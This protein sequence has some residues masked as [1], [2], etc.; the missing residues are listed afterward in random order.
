M[1][2][3]GSLLTAADIRMGD[4]FFDGFGSGTGILTITDSGAVIADNLVFG[5]DDA[6]LGDYGTG[7]L[8]IGSAVGDAAAAAGTLTVTSGELT[9]GNGTG[10]VNFNHTE[11]DYEFDLDITG[12]FDVNVYSGTTV[13]SGDSVYTGGTRVYGGVLEVNGGTLS[14]ADVEISNG[15]GSDGAAVITGAGST[16][17]TADYFT[18][19]SDSGTGTLTI[20]DGGALTSGFVTVG[21]S[22]GEGFAL[23]TGAG[24]VLT[25]LG[26]FI[27]G[28]DSTGALTVSE[29]GEV[30]SDTLVFGDDGG[31]GELNV[32]A[33]VG[34]AAAGVGVLTI[35]SGELETGTGTGIVNFNHTGVG[36]AFGLGINGA[37][38]V[39]HYAGETALGAASDYTGET[40]VYGGL[41]S[42]E[43]GVTA[44]DGGVTVG[45]GVGS[46]G[47]VL[48]TG[49]GSVWTTGD[50]LVGADGGEGLLTIAAGGVAEAGGDAVVGTDAS[51]LG[52]VVVTGT[53][54]LWDI[55]DTL[56][57]GIE[58]GD[59]T[60][61]VEDGG[62]VTSAKGYVGVGL[63]S[64]GHALI[65]GTGSSWT[66]TGDLMV[67]TE[68]DDADIT[69]E[70]GAVVNTGGDAVVGEGAGSVGTATV[71]GTGSAWNVTGDLAVGIDGGDGTLTVSDDGTVESATG[72]V[73]AGGTGMALI[74][75]TGSIWTVTGDLDIGDDGT[76][77]VADAGEV[78]ADGINIDA[79][80]LLGGDGFV[81]GNV[82]NGG[83]VRPGILGGGF[84]TLTITG[85]YTGADGL[86]YLRTALGD[87]SSP[88]DI[89]VID[90]G[91]ATGSTGIFIVNTLPDCCSGAATAG[92]G[93]LIVDAQNGAIIDSDA[94]TLAE[95]VEAGIY[96]YNL[97]QGMG[98]DLF[99]QSSG[100]RPI[101]AAY[102]AAP[103]LA[104][105]FAEDALGNV[106]DRL[107]PPEEKAETRYSLNG[108]LR[109]TEF[110]EGVWMRAFGSRRKVD[111]GSA[112]GAAYKGS[113]AGVQV[114]KDIWR[115]EN[116]NGSRDHAG[117]Y[118]AQGHADADATSNLGNAGDISLDATAAG[119]YW[120]RHGK[121][122]VYAALSG[123]YARIH[124]LKVKSGT[125]SISPGGDSFG[126][127]AEIGKTFRLRGAVMLEPSAQVMYQ[128]TRF[129][130]DNDGAATVRIDDLDALTARLGL[131]ASRAVRLAGGNTLEPW[132]RLDLLHKETDDTTVTV[133]GDRFTT[134][135]GGTQ[136]EIKLGITLTAAERRRR[137][138]FGVITHKPT[139]PPWALFAAT[140]YLHD[141]AGP[142]TQAVSVQI[143]AKVCW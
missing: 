45:T 97:F 138:T 102:G 62:T 137:T 136:A 7:I 87:D 78:A 67:G 135:G 36:Y 127:S 4:S 33:A 44:A 94:F 1:T 64:N 122:G 25:S 65:T 74:T 91:H 6:G 71:T 142:G 109:S 79:G 99:L 27:V 20:E 42:L 21:S 41:L 51:S 47:A 17:T 15:V 37:F 100:L 31:A 8:N 56:Y 80:G 81:T 132:T 101:I 40:T 14:D 63:G 98:G 10:V 105:Q 22:S 12:A 2:G 106:H 19:G 107:D 121:S 112:L 73:G 143:G 3:A 90:G 86:L 141:I 93:I 139:P 59:G 66:T 60:L 123:Q 30:V 110:A 46:D 133:A 89:L 84:K 48:V 70:D 116:A 82:T 53:D 75:D 104:L 96:T 103:G 117:I 85:D 52:A 111:T 50:M 134:P 29:G 24:S 129:D 92:D 125:T 140:S 72:Q 61:T 120:T 49:A 131:R 115:R 58:S 76:V 32:G 57:I 43:G 39:N 55:A 9:T 16:W 119:A 83:T 28:E 88:S 11:M 114:G 118:L 26:D 95:P 18:V 108:D 23:V 77:V 126:A 69:I 35:A 34:D 124:A 68:E 130:A 5:I 13:L 128:H 113:T 38:D 54:S